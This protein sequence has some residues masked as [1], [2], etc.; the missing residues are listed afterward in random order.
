MSIVVPVLDE[1]AALPRLLDHFAELDGRFEVVVADGGSS[2]G[3]AELARV[4][5]IGPGCVT[6]RGRARQLNAGAAAAGGEALVFLHADTRLPY[7]A[8]TSLCAALR[9]FDSSAGTSHCASV[10]A[11]GSR[12]RSGR[13][14]RCSAGSGSTTA[15]RRSG[16]AVARSTHWAASGTWR[17]WTTTTSSGGSSGA[18]APPAYRDRR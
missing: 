3:T 2:D 11:T 10:A 17:S 15:T 5:P 14:T 16:R 8:Y 7:D 18:V 1:A 6:A 12:A 13:G 4:H 9:D